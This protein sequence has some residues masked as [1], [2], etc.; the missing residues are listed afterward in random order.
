MHASTLT[1]VLASCMALMLHGAAACD[2]PKCTVIEGQEVHC[3]NPNSWHEYHPHPTNK[4]LFIQCTTYG[5][6]VMKCGPGTV[7][8]QYNKICVHE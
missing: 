7:W 2:L 3:V 1:L 5:P 4:H 6:Q 8:S